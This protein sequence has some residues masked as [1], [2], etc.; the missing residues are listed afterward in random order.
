MGLVDGVSATMGTGPRQSSLRD[1][2]GSRRF[3]IRGLKP[4]ATVGRRSATHDLSDG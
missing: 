2:E 3:E 1:E 4:T